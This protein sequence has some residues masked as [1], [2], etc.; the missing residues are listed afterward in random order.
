MAIWVLSS[1]KSGGSESLLGQ[2]LFEKH[3]VPQPLAET[4]LTFVWEHSEWACILPLGS[5]SS[6]STLRN[7][8]EP[9]TIP[10]RHGSIISFSVLSRA[11]TTWWFLVDEKRG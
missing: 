11:G 7:H 6:L 1:V 5:G 4:G 10:K 9:S 2:F 3:Q 8:L